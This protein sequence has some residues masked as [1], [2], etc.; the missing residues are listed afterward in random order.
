MSRAGSRAT[1]TS[2]GRWRR[3]DRAR[4]R[5]RARNRDRARGRDRGT[6][7]IEFL[8]FL[9]I[10]LA[11]ALGVVQLGIAAYAVQQAGTGA[12]AAARAYSQD[13]ADSAADPEAVGRAAMSG[14]VGERANFAGG[15][16]GDQVEVTVTVEIPSVIPG[17]DHLGTA[18][19]S[20]TMPLPDTEDGTA[21]GPGPGTAVYVSTRTETGHGTGTTTG[22]STSTGTPKESR[23]P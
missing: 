14:W 3:R 20:A 16:G 4:G 6:V 19:R 15:P 22:T 18:A 9:P 11:I 23:T 17:V 12:R 5:D 7:S 13:K 2:G 1:S 8:G 10:L 21:P